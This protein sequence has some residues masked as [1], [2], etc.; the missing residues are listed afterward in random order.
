MSADFVRLIHHFVVPLPQ[1]GKVLDVYILNK[2]RVLLYELFSRIDLI[3]HKRGEYLVALHGV[4]Y[5]H[6]Y[7]GSVLRVHSRFPE[8]IL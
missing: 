1:Q 7:Y 3:A 8:L 6:P 5:G 2:L 4:L